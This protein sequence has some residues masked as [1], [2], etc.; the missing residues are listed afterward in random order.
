MIPEG[1][2]RLF[3]QRDA[4]Q[5]V[6]SE[7][8]PTVGQLAMD[9][10]R[11]RGQALE[12]ESALLIHRG[13][14]SYEL[15][16]PDLE[17]AVGI[18][19][20]PQVPQQPVTLLQRLLIA[21]EVID[22]LGADLGDLQVQITPAHGGLSRDDSQVDGGEVDR[23]QSAQELQHARTSHSVDLDRLLIRWEDGDFKLNI[24]LGLPDNLGGDGGKLR[25]C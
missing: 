13:A 10:I 18:R 3:S 4:R 19:A 7:R 24:R 9:L 6:D 21:G 8:F 2:F 12:K 23:I 1:G 20:I 22:I 5:V 14:V 17:A 11:Q 16:A 15:L 25:P